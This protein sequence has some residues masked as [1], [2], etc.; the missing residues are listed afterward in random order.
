MFTLQ[1][2][3]T[4]RLHDLLLV[5]ALI[6]DEIDTSFIFEG[7][8]AD[9]PTLDSWAAEE[10]LEV[11]RLSMAGLAGL[12]GDYGLLNCGAVIGGD[13]GPYIVGRPET[14]LETS[15]E[16]KIIIVGHSTS[17]LLPLFLYLGN[18][19]NMIRPTRTSV[20][21]DLDEGRADF[22]IIAGQDLPAAFE[23]GLEVVV[24]L[25]SWWSRETGLPLPLEVFG[26]RRAL[27]Q[28]AA[29]AV[30][31]GLRS[32]L[33]FAKTAKDFVSASI[34]RDRPDSGSTP[35]GLSGSYLNEF[36]TDMGTEGREAIE[37]ILRKAEAAGLVPECGLPLS[38][39]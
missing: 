20:L 10:K 38:A 31:L 25:G 22:G 30:D 26:V 18:H 24:D 35:D 1:L 27:G 23:A 32:S 34:K 37:T 12:R 4:A 28:E 11:S 36:S 7:V 39:Y 14:S 17:F 3:H 5:S 19:P 8:E 16:D 2:G 15:A 9:L 33:I 21:H 13:L 29:R 6:E